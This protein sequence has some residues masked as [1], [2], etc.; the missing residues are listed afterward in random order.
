[1]TPNTLLKEGACARRSER[2]SRPDA[3]QQIK[4][5]LHDPAT[6]ILRTGL[7]RA[8]LTLE[9]T[10]ILWKVLA[11]SYLRIMFPVSGAE[12]EEGAVVAAVLLVD[13]DKRRTLYAHPMHAGPDANPLLKHLDGPMAHPK[14]QDGADGDRATQRL[15]EHKRA[16][17]SR[18]RE[19]RP[20]LGPDEAGR[21]WRAGYT[22]A[23]RRLYFCSRCPECKWGSPFFD[24]PD[25][26]RPGREMRPPELAPA[27]TCCSDV[28]GVV[29][30]V[31]ESE[32]WKIEAAYAARGNFKVSPAPRL[33]QA[34]DGEY[35]KMVF[36]TDAAIIQA[37][38]LVAVAA[39]YHR[40]SG[41]THHVHCLCAGP[42]AEI[43]YMTGDRAFG[44]LSMGVDRQARRAYASWRRRAWLQF[45][46]DDLEEG[47]EAASAQW[48]DGFWK[49]L[50]ALFG[51]NSLMADDRGAG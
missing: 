19:E 7:S 44:L 17:W 9:P 40:P 38:S 22:W 1:M 49:A 35:V 5:A 23:L 16:L 39:C 48:L 2:A 11:G 29:A 32:A 13:L 50:G 4:T 30:D 36:H 12:L 8:G 20:T 24:G 42:E 18:F 28:K 43:V 51:G 25:P 45:W 3:A 37:G 27:P 31:I 14:A 33:V 15:L 46:L 34:L 10:P 6:S 41:Q 26:G 47:P 21:R